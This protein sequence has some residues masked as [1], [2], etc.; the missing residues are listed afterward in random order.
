M[1]FRLRNEESPQLNRLRRGAMLHKQ[2]PPIA[3]GAAATTPIP[4]AILPNPSAANVLVIAAAELPDTAAPIAA[5]CQLRQRLPLLLLLYHLPLYKLHSKN[6]NLMPDRFKDIYI[7]RVKR[8]LRFCFLFSLI[9]EY[10]IDIY[11]ISSKNKPNNTPLFS[12]T[13]TENIN[14]LF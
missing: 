2:A 12:N 7:Y 11:K 3:T 5:V 14:S 10:G 1:D 4:A 8:F 9:A 13:Q 6:T